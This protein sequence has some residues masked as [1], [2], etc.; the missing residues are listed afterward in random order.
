MNPTP[1]AA[2]ADLVRRDLAAVWHPCTQ[3][4]DHET[5]PMLPVRR[6]AGVWL[7]LHDGRQVLDAILGVVS[8][9]SVQALRHS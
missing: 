2:M 5:V 6:A 9:R 7:E 8:G 1:N 3:M 4:K